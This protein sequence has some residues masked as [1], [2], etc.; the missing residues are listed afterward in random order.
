MLRSRLKLVTRDDL[1]RVQFARGREEFESAFRILHD[2]YVSQK[3]MKPDPSG[4]RC[5]IY[6]AFPGTQVLT[7]TDRGC[8]VGTLSIIPDSDLGFPSDGAFK[9]ENDGFRRIGQRICELSG[10]AVH[11]NYRNDFGIAL[12]LMVW[13]YLYATDY[14]GA[15]VLC[16]TVDP[17]IL[18]FYSAMFGFQ[19]YGAEVR[20]EFAAGAPS[21][22]IGMQ[23]FGREAWLR[24]KYDSLPHEKNLYRYVQEQKEKQRVICGSTA[25][26]SRPLM[27][28]ELLEYLFVHKTKVLPTATAM[29]ASIIMAAHGFELDFGRANLLQGEP[30]S[31]VP[32]DRGFEAP[33]V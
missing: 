16:A 5:N 26:T 2:V 32:L 9:R 7:V 21:I 18:D 4:L 22:Y 11:E 25:R 24:E 14:M 30:V 27:T 10:F 17:R 31:L 20:Y 23:C 19:K 6:H 15:S 3:F 1:W 33:G 29:Q 8:V 12:K 28:P 13:A